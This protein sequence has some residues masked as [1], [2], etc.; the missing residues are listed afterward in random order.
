M[1][2]RHNAIFTKFKMRHSANITRC[3]HDK[4]QIRHNANTTK[5]AGAELGKAQPKLGFLENDISLRGYIWG[6]GWM[7]RGLK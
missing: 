7:A 4:M 1:Q 3:K 6:W 5:Q 2:M